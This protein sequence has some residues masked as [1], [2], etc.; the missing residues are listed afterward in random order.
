MGLLETKGWSP[1][2]ASKD[3]IVLF[4]ARLQ[5]MTEDLDVQALKAKVLVATVSMRKEFVSSTRL[6][7]FCM[8][9]NSKPR[10][11]SIYRAERAE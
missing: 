5:D 1:T 2:H 10:S 4:G 11:Y 9:S 8:R 6:S 3:D 7:Q